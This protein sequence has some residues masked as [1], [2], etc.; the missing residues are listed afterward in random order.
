MKPQY[1]SV[2]ILIG[3]CY[4]FTTSSVMANDYEGCEYKRQNLERQID[5]ARAH[6]NTHRVAGL[7]EALRQ[8]NEHC[9][10]NQLL[11][12]KENKV[13][14]KQRKVTKR[15]YELEQARISG[16]SEKIADR[17]ETC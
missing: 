1:L 5:Y 7:Q 14:E 2:T 13:A 10:D 17:G 11:K 6:N 9:T 12:Q 8:V 3:L 4:F 15:Q 16:K